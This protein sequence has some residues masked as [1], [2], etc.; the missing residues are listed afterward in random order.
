MQTGTIQIAHENKLRGKGKVIISIQNQKV[1]GVELEAVSSQR[2]F[3]SSIKGMPFSD[4]I[5][6]SS[7]IDQSQSTFHAIA[8]TQ[9][10]ENAYLIEVSPQTKWFRE[11]ALQLALGYH[12]AQRLVVHEI[13]HHLKLNQLLEAEGSKRFWRENMTKIYQTFSQSLS[14]WVGGPIENKA[15]Q[16]GGYYQSPSTETIQQIIQRLETIQEKVIELIS[17]WEKMVDSKKNN[18]TL[19]AHANAQYRLNGGII[20]DSEA[21]LIASADYEKYFQSKKQ[22]LFIQQG[23]VARIALNKRELNAKA[24]NACA[25]ILKNDSSQLSQGLAELIELLHVTNQLLGE[26][27]NNAFYREEVKIIQPKTAVFGKCT[28]ESATGILIHQVQIDARGKITDWII[29]TPLEQQQLRIR[30]SIRAI[31]EESIHETK[32][33]IEKKVENYIRELDLNWLELLHDESFRLK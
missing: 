28:L 30:Q 31:V 32:T 22:E 16:L 17:N 15:I 23:P 19:M 20:Q 12:H 10:I 13:P 3:E 18:V 27:N 26:L 8:V 7:R 2:F 4:L 24:Y 1:H 21:Q 25:P 9:A 11:Q 6:L 33:E 14:E 5:P 29:H